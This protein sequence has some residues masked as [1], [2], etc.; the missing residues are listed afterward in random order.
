MAVSIM[1][2]CLEQVEIVQDG[3]CEGI[4][5]ISEMV[6]GMVKVFQYVI[7]QALDYRYT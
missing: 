2:G 6:S 5:D 7:L 1:D 4:V 3:S